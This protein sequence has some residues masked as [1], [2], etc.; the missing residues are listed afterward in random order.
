M[1][2]GT[3]TMVEPG[4]P[5]QSAAT[6]RSTRPV[7]EGSPPRMVVCEKLT[8][9]TIR[10]HTANTGM[11]IRCM[12]RRRR[13]YRPEPADAI[14]IDTALASSITGTTLKRDSPQVSRWPL[15]SQLG[16]SPRYTVS[17]PQAGIAN[18]TTARRVNDPAMT[19]ATRSAPRP[20]MSRTVTTMSGP[21][22]TREERTKDYQGDPV[23]APPRSLPSSS[24]EK[25]SEDPGTGSFREEWHVNLAPRRWGRDQGHRRLDHQSREE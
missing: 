17:R 19:C 2:L 10:N 4:R 7:Q 11:P 15:T 18:Q 21:R 23:G 8:A 16:P 1:R 25:R 6:T 13:R 12:I 20:R 14:R 22:T 24:E 3:V 9:I 5:E